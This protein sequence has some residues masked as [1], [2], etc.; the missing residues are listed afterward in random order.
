MKGGVRIHRYR[1]YLLHAK[2]VR[3]DERLG[4]VGSSDVDIR[5]FQLNEEVSLLLLDRSSVASLREIQ[6]GYIAGSDELTLGEWRARSPFRK[7]LEG[8]AR[9][10]GPLL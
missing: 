3:I 4:I 2:S 1:D 7:F 8:G 9:I 5:S 6:D 10:V